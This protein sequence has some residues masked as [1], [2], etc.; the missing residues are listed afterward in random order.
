[1]CSI[2]TCNMKFEHPGAV[3]IDAEFIP[4]TANEAALIEKIAPEL[5]H[6]AHEVIDVKFEGGALKVH[7][8][9]VGESHMRKLGEDLKEVGAD[10]ADAGKEAVLLV[11]DSFTHLRRHLAA[12]IAGKEGSAPVATPEVVADICERTSQP[13]VEAEQKSK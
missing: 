7:V 6:A 12:F 13:Q 11:G 1:M 5:K 9:L 4:G 2:S 8:E 10:L 3:V